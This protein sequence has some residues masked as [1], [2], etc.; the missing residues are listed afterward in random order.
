MPIIFETKRLR[1]EKVCFGDEAFILEL[2]NTKGWIENIGD[3]KITTLEGA[4]NEIEEKFHQVYKEQGMGFYKMVLKSNNI[5]I[6]ICGLIKR[7]YL[8]NVDLGF[9]ILPLFSRRGFTYEAATKMIEYGKE[10]LKLDKICAITNKQNVASIK[11]LNK[12]G[13]VFMDEVEHDETG[14]RLNLFST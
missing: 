6:G 1:L 10:N 4:K 13:L 12:L 9:A 7:S 8:K 11:L 5:P 14:E 3:K 2:I